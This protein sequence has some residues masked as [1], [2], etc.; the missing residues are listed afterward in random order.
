MKCGERII[1]AYS[2]AHL[3]QMKV[4]EG[5][6]IQTSGIYQLLQKQF[7]IQEDERYRNALL[8]DSLD[9]T[10]KADS[11][12]IGLHDLEEILKSTNKNV[13]ES[14]SD[15]SEQG[16]DDGFGLDDTLNTVDTLDDINDLT[17]TRKSKS[18]KRY[19]F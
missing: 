12:S 8:S 2:D 18:T 3:A 4:L 16:Y 17:K 15:D 7:K 14:K 19:D 11:N 10:K 6:L 13:G 1:A 5:I 9:K